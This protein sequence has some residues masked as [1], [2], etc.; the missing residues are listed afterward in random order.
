MLVPPSAIIPFFLSVF[1]FD[2]S[3]NDPTNVITLIG[4]C[5]NGKSCLGAQIN[6]NESHYDEGFKIATA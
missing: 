1:K 3:A 6:S 4:F 5:F 2:V